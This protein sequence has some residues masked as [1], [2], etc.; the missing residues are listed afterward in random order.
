MTTDEDIAYC[1]EEIPRIVHELRR[2]FI[3]A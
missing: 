2:N 1:T 3:S